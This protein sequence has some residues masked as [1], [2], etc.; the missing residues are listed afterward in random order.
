MMVYIILACC[1]A[2]LGGL[3]V[4]APKK[5][6]LLFT[7]ALL[8]TP[9]FGAF[10]GWIYRNGLFYF[11]W[12]FIVLVI[13][14]VISLTVRLPRRLLL[15]SWLLF[16]LAV[17]GLFGVAVSGRDVDKYVLR[18]IRP[19]LIIVESVIF[20]VIAKSRK[21][22]LSEL[23]LLKVALVAGISPFLGFVLI[24]SGIYH[25]EDLFYQANTYRYI[26]IGSYVSAVALIWMTHNAGRLFKL[27]PMI[28]VAAVIACVSAVILSGMRSLVAATIIGCLI[29]G[30][31]RIGRLVLA[32]MIGATVV[33]GFLYVSLQAEV[34]RVI[35]ATSLSGL[36]AQLST[37]FG[38]AMGV[39]A[40]LEWWQWL[41]GAGLGTTFDIPWFVYRGLDM[42]NNSVDSMYLTLF[43][44]FGMFAIVYLWLFLK[45]IGNA[46]MPAAIRRNVIIFLGVLGITMAL[47]YQRYVIGI[48]VFSTFLTCLAEGFVVCRKPSKNVVYHVERPVC[49]R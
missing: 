27:A 2:A 47:P 21:I 33:G 14:Y 16:V 13:A 29:A 48:A 25:V 15:D 9:S 7:I 34:A 42:Q 22:S 46:Y 30:R 39:I 35:Q 6:V 28:M 37:R 32:G 18:D 4:W 45:Y 1:N 31:V 36:I 24:N 5:G 8:L 11:D 26:G 38:P 40:E 23:T 3:T 41:I 12:Y 44:K 20:F 10:D 19:F 17:I 43:V 49:T